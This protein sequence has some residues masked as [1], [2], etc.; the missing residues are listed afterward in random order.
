MVDIVYSIKKGGSR[1]G[2][3]ELRYS[4]RSIEKHLKNYRNIYLIG[5]KPDWIQNVIHIEAKDDNPIP[6]NNILNKLYKACDHPDISDSFLFFNDDHFLLQDFDAP[7]FPY[8]Y[9]ATLKT[10][11]RNRKDGYGMRVR[12]TMKYL[13]GNG[14]PEKHFDIHYPI[15]Y[16]K[17]KF[18]PC[19]EK[20]P[21]TYHGYVIKSIYANTLEIGGASIPDCKYTTPPN[22][23][24]ICFS[25]HPKPSPIVCKWLEERF[26]DK[27][28]YE[29]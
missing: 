25:T 23:V 27:S 10:F 26:P 14:K 18:K 17:A 22:S 11:L 7:N 6:D 19:F 9:W 24:N 16:E 4:L 8:F 28:R 1:W 15:I 2:D 29:A 5:Y 13:V 12:N 20:L 3:N 21:V